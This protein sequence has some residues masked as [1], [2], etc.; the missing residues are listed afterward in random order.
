[1][2]V[3]QVWKF[4]SKLFDRLSSTRFR[5]DIVYISMVDFDTGWCLRFVYC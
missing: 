1:L 5:L 3:D 2:K 4:G